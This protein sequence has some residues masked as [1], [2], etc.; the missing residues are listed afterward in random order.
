MDAA[1]ASVET[2]RAPDVLAGRRFDQADPGVFDR[3][4]CIGARAAKPQAEGAGKCRLGPAGIGGSMSARV[5]PHTTPSGARRGARYEKGS[6]RDEKGRQTR[7]QKIDEI[8]ELGRGE[9]ER[10]VPWRLVADHAVGGVDGLVA[11]A[12]GQAAKREP[13]GGRCDAVGKILGKA[14]DC[15]AGDACLIEVCHVAADD[16]CHRSAASLQS[17]VESLRDGKDMR[18]EA[19][20]RDEARRH[21]CGDGKACRAWN[22]RCGEPEAEKSGGA[23]S[24]RYKQQERE[25]T[26]DAARRKGLILMIQAAVGERNQTANPGD[27][28]TERAKHA[29]RIANTGLDGDSERRERQSCGQIHA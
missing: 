26:Q 12:P 3:H 6:N 14:L 11:K 21:K 19:A 28:M 1:G 10:R 2:E 17:C 25:K 22:L 5:A 16:F 7:G 18:I 4:I 15:R 20:L 24:K 23:P 8:I 27:R 9:A 13:E 29:L